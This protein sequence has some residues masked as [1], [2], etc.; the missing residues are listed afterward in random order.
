MQYV[1]LDTV[2][3]RAISVVGDDNDNELMK[4]YAREWVWMAVIDLPVT[5]DNVKVCNIAAKNLML[6]KPDD[7]RRFLEIS[8]YDA[9]GCYVPHMFHAGKKRIYPHFN[10]FHNHHTATGTTNNH[11]IHCEPVDLSEDQFAFI[12][13]TNG[14]DVAGGMIRYFAYPIDK[15]GLPMVREEDV[16]TCVYFV[17]FMASMKKNDN[18]SAIQQNELLFKQEA[19]RARAKRK[20]NRSEDENKTITSIMTRMIPSFNRHSF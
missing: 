17:R 12:I 18:R 10:R 5:E 7:M 8:L 6:K 1:P 9:N 16:M 20:S 15:D 14:S 13:G 4:L 2:V 19:D 3:A 11:H